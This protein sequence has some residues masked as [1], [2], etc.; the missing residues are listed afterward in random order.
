MKDPRNPVTPRSPYP[1]R[2]Y[3][4]DLFRRCRLIPASEAARRLGMKLSSG[5]LRRFALCPIHGD[6]RPS[7]MFDLAGRW[8]CFGCGRGGDAVDLYALV[9][10]IR[11][12][13]AARELLGL[14]PEV[15][16]DR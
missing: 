15:R 16:H 12:I 1:I 5:R 3:D 2:R 14:E 7:M 4:N 10:G 11:P 6:S 9:K 13:D 8:H